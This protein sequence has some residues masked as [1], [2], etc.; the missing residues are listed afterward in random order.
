[1]FHTERLTRILI[2][3]GIFCALVYLGKFVAEVASMFSHLILL[4][5]LA[6][7]LAF[8]LKP[9]ALWLD[10]G[11]VPDA[12]VGWSRQRWG[13]RPADL[14]SAV[15]VPYGLAAVL[16]YLMMLFGL[17]ALLV[18][19]VPRLVDQLLRLSDQL[20]DYVEGFPA[21]W[22]GVQD[23]AVQRFGVDRETLV[24]LLPVEDFVG[25]AQAA[26]PDLIG[27]VVKFVQGIASGVAN[28]LLVLILSLYIMLDSKRVSDQLY[29]VMPVRYQDEFEFINRTIVRTFG[30]F[31]RGKV[32]QG[33]IHAVFVGVVMALFGLQYKIVTA[34]FTG[35]MM[36]I[37]Q[38]GAPVAMVA[39]PLAS[40]IQGSD[41]T[42]PLFIVMLVFQQILIR[43]VMPNLTSDW[44]GMPPLLMMISVM[45]G[46]KIVGVWGFF[47]STP[48]AGAIYIVTTTFLEH[49]KQGFDAQDAQSA[50]Q[51]PPGAAL[52]G[53]QPGE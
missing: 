26:L 30:N 25:E 31:L 47:F 18:L 48:V 1:M 27:N 29:R 21:W 43:F 6:W 10:R 41:A 45:V 52:A 22:E 53:A 51:Q 24:D 11:P 35:L 50:T 32:V 19:V 5:A 23:E 46:A 14:L 3:L 17:G 20:P 38:L 7:M 4:L 49:L 9:I 44:I 8:V 36:F 12:W 28:T 15:R 16:L 13:E 40:L 37:P 2:T 34:L 39:P 42:L 33:I